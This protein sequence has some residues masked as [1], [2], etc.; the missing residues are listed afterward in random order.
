MSVI[1]SILTVLAVLSLP[2]MYIAE[3]KLRVARKMRPV[4]GIIFGS[5][6]LML[7]LVYILFN[8]KVKSAAGDVRLWAEDFFMSYFSP[9]IVTTSV[10]TALFA[11]AAFIGHKMRRT[12]MILAALLPFVMTSMTFFVV[13]LASDGEFAVDFYIRAL[14]PG[15]ALLPHLVPLCE[16]RKKSD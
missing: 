6:V 14:A 13:F 11:S 4:H 9:A 3:H 10:L 8:W 7:V 16:R 1:V 15:L 2:V 5:G 12:R